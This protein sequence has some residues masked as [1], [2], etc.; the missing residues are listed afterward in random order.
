M[1]LNSDNL[2][3]GNFI[4]ERIGDIIP[5]YPIIAEQGT[6]A[7]FCVY[8]RNSFQSKNT[9]DRYNYEEQ[10]NLEISIC[11][12]TYEHSI[13][14]A[15][16]IKDRLEAFSGVWRTTFING[17]YLQNA[18]EDWVSNAYIQKLYFSIEVDNSMTKGR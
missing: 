1:R 9:K 13:K 18:T 4:K 8:R 11:A 15:Q 14:L 6:D 17:I 3:I 5:V 16:S 2:E 12:L 7:P 10:I